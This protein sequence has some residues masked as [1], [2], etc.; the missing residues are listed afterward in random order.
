MERA[1]PES[2]ADATGRVESPVLTAEP[3]PPPTHTSE[4]P[5]SATAAK[6]KPVG[7][8]ANAPAAASGDPSSTGILDTTQ[9]PAGRKIVVDG[10]VIGSSPRRVAVRCGTHRIQ[11]GDLPPES[12]QLPCG[13]EVTFTD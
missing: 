11:I 6:P 4:P 9:L 12:I 7:G 13:G 2:S 8:A 5:P 1:A 3:R 10:R